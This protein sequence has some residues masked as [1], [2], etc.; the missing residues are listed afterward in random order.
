MR[1]VSGLRDFPQKRLGPHS[2]STYDGSVSRL[3]SALF[4][5]NSTHLGGDVR[6]ARLAT[7]NNLGSFDMML[8]EMTRSCTE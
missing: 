3:A 2:V 1:Q 4:N 8:P 5:G 6:I 7:L